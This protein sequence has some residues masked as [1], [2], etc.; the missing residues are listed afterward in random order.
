MQCL[1][2]L[3]QNLLQVNLNVVLIEVVERIL[4]EESLKLSI[5]GV[6]T[7]NPNS[8]YFQPKNF[9]KFYKKYLVQKFLERK[10]ISNF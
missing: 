4:G 5:I 9:N 1:I 8:V 7:T 10:E 6:L 3:M 2:L